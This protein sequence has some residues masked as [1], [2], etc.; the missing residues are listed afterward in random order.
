MALKLAIIGIGY[1]GSEII[2]N[3]YKFQHKI[4]LKA[5]FDIEKD[6]MEK[7]TDLH[8]N[9][10][11]MSSTTDFDDCDIIVESA[12]QQVVETVFDKMIQSGKIFIPLSVGAFISYD[13]LYSKY[14]QLDESQKKLI[15]LPSGAI[16]GFDCIE[17]LNLVGIQ[18]AELTTRKPLKVFENH[19]YVKDRDL[20]LSESEKTLIFKGNA[21]K[22][23][24]IFPRSINVAARLAL[25]TLGPKKTAVSIYS[26]PSI[27]KNIHEIEISSDVGEY[28]FSF[29]N[30]PS[31]INPRTS[32]LAALSILEALGKIS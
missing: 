13:N 29:Q 25:S 31:P 7:V 32:W 19:K 16:G 5:V 3:L 30:N 12:T 20:K 14:T 2:K 15:K 22:A 23:A 18:K 28:K 21:K 24:Q 4:E 6:K 11:L 26:E 27:N 10:R 8:P 9:V 17:A 1:I